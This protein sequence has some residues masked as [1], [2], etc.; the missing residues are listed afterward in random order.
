MQRR[1]YAKEENIQEVCCISLFNG[2]RVEPDWNKHNTALSSFQSENLH[3]L[4]QTG[5]R[6]KTDHACLFLGS[7]DVIFYY[8]AACITLAKDKSSTVNNNKP[9]ETT[10]YLH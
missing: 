4:T 5:R 2:Y 1:V 8:N 6:V 7:E 9:I 10:M 3:I